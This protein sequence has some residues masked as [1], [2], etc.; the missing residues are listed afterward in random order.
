VIWVPATLLAGL[1]QAWRT[2]VQLRVR[3]N[4]SVNAAGLV[5]YLF[6][7]PVALALLAA[8]LALHGWTAAVADPRRLL[9]WASIGGLSQ[10]IGTNLLLMAFHYRSYVVGTA[11]A[12]TEAIQ[13]ALLAWLLLGEALHPLAW[14]GIA[15]VVTGVFT[16]SLGAQRLTPRAALTMIAQPAAL[17]GLGAAFAFA[18]T[19]ICVKGATLAVGGPDLVLRA[20]IAL[21]VTLTLQVVMQGGY[22]LAREPE[23]LRRIFATWRTSGQVG[24][25]AALG[26]ACWFTGFA[27]GPV[28]LVRVVGQV[29]V[30]LTPLFARYYLG[31]RLH[32]S[33]LAGLFI[34]TVGII[35]SIVG[36]LM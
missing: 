11:Y 29:E 30:L 26:S 17:C 22:L 1:L 3:E 5:R 16:L 18:V 15:V 31:E 20:L 25:L 36:G 28:A 9:L 2:A 34:V 12:K 27:T 14:L 7:L 21:V 24:V 35:L 23:Q 13:G 6:G 8:Y 19:A 4:L 33:D 32:G 10:I